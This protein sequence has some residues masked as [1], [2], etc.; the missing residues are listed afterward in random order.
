[1]YTI[2]L[3][4]LLTANPPTPHPGPD[5][6]LAVLYSGQAAAATALTGS[7]ASS[8]YCST[9][10]LTDGTLCA[11]LALAASHGLAVHVVYDGTAGTNDANY[12]ATAAIRASGGTV[13]AATMPHKIENQYLAADGI[14]TLQGNYYYSPTA[15][16]IGAYSAAISGTATPFANI[17]QFNAI[18][19]GGTITA[20]HQYDYKRLLAGV[21]PL[22]LAPLI[23]HLGKQPTHAGKRPPREGGEDSPPLEQPTKIETTERG[24]AILTTP[25]TRP[26]TAPRT[27]VTHDDAAAPLARPRR[28]VPLLDAAAAFRPALARR[29]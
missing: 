9:W 20:S 19:S 5:R 2:A 25:A 6:V 14:Y 21:K 10:R 24:E 15:V 13:W 11:A 7:A 8:I 18:T 1:M 27:R 26:G 17:T 4:V 3:A 16:Q 23:E 28:P 22:I 12:I 29:R